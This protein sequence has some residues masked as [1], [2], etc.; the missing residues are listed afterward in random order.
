MI[1]RSAIIVDLRCRFE[2]LTFSGNSQ[3]NVMCSAE[4]DGLPESKKER[5][6]QVVVRQSK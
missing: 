2:I 4:V 5:T 6:Y 3:V 1:E